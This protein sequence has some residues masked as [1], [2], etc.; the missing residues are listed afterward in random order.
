MSQSVAHMVLIQQSL[1]CHTSSTWISL[2]ELYF[3]MHALD[4]AD[5]DGDEKDTKAVLE[6]TTEDFSSQ[7]VAILKR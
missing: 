5:T 4:K 1:L 7:D 3:V 6:E 2:S